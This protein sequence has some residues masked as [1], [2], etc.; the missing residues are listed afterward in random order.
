[1]Q[2]DRSV[3]VLSYVDPETQSILLC[4]LHLHINNYNDIV[5]FLLQ[6]NMDIR[7][8]GLGAAVKVLTYY[9]SNYITNNILQVHISLQAI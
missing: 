3:W 8:I 4:Q 1:M 9:I 7:F 5:I 2:I 6:C